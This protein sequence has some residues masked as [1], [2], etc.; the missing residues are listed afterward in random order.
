MLDY[1]YEKMTFREMIRLFNESKY[2]R[3]ATADNNQP[4]AIPMYF[5]YIIDGGKIKFVLRSGDNGL[6]MRF[7]DNNN[8]VALLD[9]S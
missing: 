7:M 6:K 1:I 9:I 3:L 5:K 4:Y 8:K 2:C